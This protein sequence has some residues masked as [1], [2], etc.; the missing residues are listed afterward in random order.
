MITC[1]TARLE[2]LDLALNW[3]ADEG[4]N[5]GLDDAAAFFATD[6]AGFFVA[7][8]ADDTPLAAISVVNHSDAF[9]FLGLYLVRPAYRGRGIGLQLWQ[10]ALRHAGQRTVGLDGVEAQQQNYVASGFAHAGGTTRFSGKVHGHTDPSIR[11]AGPDDIPD[12][13]AQEATASGVAKPA[14]LSA[15]FGNTAHRTTLVSESSQ[16]INGLC[17]VRTCR[18]GVKIGPL[19]AESTEF[20]ERLICHAATLSETTVTLDV[21]ETSQTLSGL[22]QSYGLKAGFKTARMYRGPFTLRPHDLYAVASLELG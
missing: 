16:G 22:C 19:V 8:D 12:L 18:A 21:P 10:H 11:T 20:A 6:P 2:D 7:V 5:P 14:Y 17:T 9:A 13:I 3:A 1:R 4:W 15:W